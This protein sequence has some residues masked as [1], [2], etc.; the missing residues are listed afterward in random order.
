MPRITFNP[1]GRTIEAGEGMDLIE[2]ARRAGEDIDAPCGGNGTCGRCLVRVTSGGVR[3]DASAVV[4]PE[5]AAAGFIPACRSYVTDQDCIVEIPE[6]SVARSGRD[7]DISP[8]DAIEPVGPDGELIRT[9]GCMVPP[10]GE[11][12]RSDLERLAKALASAG[13]DADCPLPVARSLAGALRG[14]GGRVGVDVTGAFGRDRMVRVVAGNPA[15]AGLGIAV[16]L[17]TTTVAVALVDTRSGAV[18]STRVAYNEQV[19][20]GLDVISRV[21][22]ASRAG[23]LEAL[24]AA[25]LGTINRLLRAAAFET[26]VDPGDITSA[27]ISGNTVMT[28]LALGLDPEHIRLAPYTPTVLEVPVYAAA[29][30][31]IEIAPAAPVL[32]SPCVG[33]YVG[34]D[35][36]AG[37]LLTDLASGNE[38]ISLFIDVGTNGEIVIGNRDFLLTCACSAGPAFE[39]GGIDRGMRAAPG[40]ISAVRVNPANGEPSFSVIGGGEPRGICGSGM[41]DLVAELFL[42]GW[43]DA[44]GRLDRTRSTRRIDRAGRRASYELAG[45]HE[46]KHSIRVSETDIENIMRAKAAIY[47][48]SAFMLGSIGISY[49]DISRFYVAG[50]FGKT[51]DVENA[52][53]IGLLPDVPRDRFA[54]I[55]NASLIGSCR[56]L[57]SQKYRTLQGDLSRRMTYLDPGADPRYMDH[58]TAALFLPHTDGDLFP[59]VAR[60]VPRA[61]A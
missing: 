5:D 39:G 40:A 41:I 46:G 53:A 6:S 24:R 7:G 14:D 36:T 17:G 56:L 8:G 35:I 32:F 51:L 12:G 61:G 15:R 9:V 27:V 18:I 1:S 52:V 55:G 19:S 28:H 34:G 11:D 44:A 57:V 54:Y 47:A 37:V 13:V 26:R 50:G 16:D 21:N 23:G 31:G 42:S 20:M 22:Y 3:T 49:N 43:L 33:S 38:D 45:D 2:A 60:R 48:A 29:E 30:I 59:S 58:Y 4:A 25:A 10:P